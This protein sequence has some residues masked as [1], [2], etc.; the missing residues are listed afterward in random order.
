VGPRAR[1]GMIEA[2]TRVPRRDDPHRPGPVLPR[3]STFPGP[4]TGDLPIN[5]PWPCDAAGRRA[6]EPRARSVL[7]PTTDSEIL[8]GKVLSALVP[9]LIAIWASS[10]IFMRLTDRVVQSELGAFYYPSLAITVV[11]LALV[12]LACLVAVELAVIISSR[13]SDVRSAQQISG[14]LFVPFI[15]IYLAAEIGAINLDAIG[16]LYLSGILGVSA[17]A[18]FYASRRTFGREEILTRWK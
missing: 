5:V 6:R 9:T 3:A 10:V 4:R 16:M 15:L 18:L 12:P 8:L 1:E 11:L 17:L 13:V 14:L 7:P 2:L